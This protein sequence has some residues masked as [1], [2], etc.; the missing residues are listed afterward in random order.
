MKLEERTFGTP[1]IFV[2]VCYICCH[3]GIQLYTHNCTL[4]SRLYAVWCWYL[5]AYDLSPFGRHPDTFSVKASKSA[6]IT[7]GTGISLPAGVL[8]GSFVTHSKDV[9]GEAILASVCGDLETLLYFLFWHLNTL[10]S[11]DTY[12]ILLVLD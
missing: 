3:N 12:A 5:S 9:C 7:N 1:C 2:L 8:W 10:L 11:V 4:C 6:Y